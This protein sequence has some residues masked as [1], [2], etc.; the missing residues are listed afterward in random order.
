MARTLT[1]NVALQYANEATIGVLPG[2]PEW[3]LLEPNAISAYG[4]AI[5]T[6]AR[7]P[8]SQER[9]RKKGTVTNLESAVEFDGDLTMESFENFAEGFVFAEFANADFNFRTTGGVLPPPVASAATWTIESLTALMGTKLLFAA[10]G[11]WPLVHGRGYTNSANNGLHQLTIDPASTD[12]ILTTD[13]TLVV[14]TPGTNATLEVCGIRSAIGDLALTV[15]GSTATLVS[16]ADIADW[17]T[18]GL[19]V[20]QYIHIGSATTAGA[21]Q[22]GMGTGT[23][24]VGYARVTSISTTTLNLDKLSAE[25]V[26]DAANSTLTDVMFGRFLRNVAVTAD[27]DDSRYLERSYQ[28]ETI[29][30]DLGGAG[31]DEFE[32]AIGNF[33][34][35][36]ALNL[37]LTDKA[38]ATWGFI[39]TN[40][41]D[42]VV[43]GSR[44]TNAATAVSPL[45]T[46]ALN[47]SSNIVSLTTDLITLTS[48]VCFKSLT[49]TIR[50]NVTPE[51]CLGTL[52]ASFVNAGLFEV[53]LEG[54]MLFTNKEIVN[55]VKNNT[56]TTFS[57]IL[58]NDDGGL[59]IDLPSMTFGGGDREYP[60]DQ[61]VLVNLT[62]ETFND[63]TGTVP[64]V[65]LGL[66]FFPLVPF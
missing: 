17:S 6:V 41:D 43:A 11:P 56:T 30:P 9:G 37:P 64:N 21:A 12:V 7:R 35:E 44:K 46:V 53:N 27:A 24:I 23:D 38:T 26:T 25:L 36:L 1:N 10:A 5:T 29:Y 3:K 16:A 8:I 20:G 51:N 15:S 34:N 14:E 13:S 2:S 33:A 19:Y 66:S 58:S 61:S 52:G 47:T 31:N 54:Q 57:A 60:V 48:D 63:P 45:R 65:S 28:F 55:A 59:A 49:L 22:N 32:Y 4:A 39:G 62:G 42:I 50:N 18:H 40:A